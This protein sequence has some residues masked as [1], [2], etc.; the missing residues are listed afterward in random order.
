LDACR[1]NPFAS[2][3]RSLDSGLARMDGPVGSFIAYATAPGSVA[4]DGEGRNGLYTEYLLKALNKP[5]LTIEQTFKQVRTGVIKVTSG[6]QVPW[7]SS[8][9]MGEFVFLSSPSQIKQKALSQSSPV[10]QTVMQQVKHL[11]LS[12]NVPDAVVIV[13]NINRGLI[14]NTGILGVESLNDGKV[15]IVVQARG[16]QSQRR[17]ISL[18][19]NQTEKV[20]IELVP[21]QAIKKINPTKGIDQN[22]PGSVAS[23]LAGKRFLTTNKIVFQNIQGKNIRRTVPSIETAVIKALQSANIEFID[24][25]LLASKALKQGDFEDFNLDELATRHQLNYLLRI[26]VNVREMPIKIIK[27]EMKTV[28]GTVTFELLDLKSKLLLGSVS[29][30]FNKAGLDSTRVVKKQVKKLLPEMS[31]E[32]IETVCDSISQSLQY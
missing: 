6:Q 17:Q 19:S 11:Q 1:N 18:N 10:N 24:K 15:D 32:L 4:A 25:T 9:L 12:S 29:R 13:N 30:D 3:F 23:C 2:S 5:D 20:H 8:S 7:E 21:E 28:N 27:T 22:L 31:S 14:K 16:Y 26:M